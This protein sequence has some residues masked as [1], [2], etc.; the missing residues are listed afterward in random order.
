MTCRHKTREP[1]P[2]SPWVHRFTGSHRSRDRKSGTDLVPAGERTKRKR[3]TAVYKQRRAA[4][5]SDL[6]A[7]FAVRRSNSGPRAEDP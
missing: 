6:A 7:T 4:G 1:D 2:W 5:L 3:C